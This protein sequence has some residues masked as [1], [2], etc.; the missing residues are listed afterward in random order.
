MSVQLSEYS[1]YC[2]HKMKSSNNDKYRKND[3]GLLLISVHCEWVNITIRIFRKPEDL[4]ESIAFGQNQLKSFLC[5]LRLFEHKDAIF[6][7][8]H[9]STRRFED[10]YS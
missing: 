6:D 4:G 3:A 10:F 2:K 5:V 9:I 7:L 1:A 8:C